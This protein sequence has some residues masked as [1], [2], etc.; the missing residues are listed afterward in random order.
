MST[1]HAGTDQLL[2]LELVSELPRKVS[3]R[4]Q[5]QGQSSEVFG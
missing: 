1:V 4:V 5:A 3:L 2:A